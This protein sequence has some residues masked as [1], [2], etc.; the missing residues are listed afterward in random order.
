MNLRILGS[1]NSGNIF[2]WFSLKR[3][4]KLMSHWNAN[5][6]KCNMYVLFKNIKLLVIQTI[7]KKLELV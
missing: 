3:E 6:Y 5:N 1:H 7:V 4:K 2:Q